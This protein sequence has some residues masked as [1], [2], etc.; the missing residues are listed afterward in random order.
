MLAPGYMRVNGKW[1]RNDST[2][3]YRGMAAGGRYTTVDDMLKF[4]HVL[5]SGKLISKAMLK[6]AMQPFFHD[7]PSGYGY[8]LGFEIYGDKQLTSFGHEGGADGMNGELRVFQKL[9]RVIV[10]LSNLDPPAAHRL[11]DYYSLRMPAA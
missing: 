8:G 9:N 1:E 11:V 10:V 7:A 4:V 6:M 3:P 5:Q 2:L